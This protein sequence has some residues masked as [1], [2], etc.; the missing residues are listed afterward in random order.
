VRLRH[1]YIIRCDEVV[2]GNDGAPVELHCSV[3]LESR[4]GGANAD[5]KVKGVIHWVSAVHGVH[6]EV[7]LYD[8]LFTTPNPGGLK[9]GRTLLDVLN[10][11]SLQVKQSIVEPH[12]VEQGPGLRVQFERT[13]YFYRDPETEE[14]AVPVFNRI[15][16]LRDTWA[17]LE[18]ANAG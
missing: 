16:T 8:R 2:H 14:G 12:L 15:I 3:D 4:A 13:G 10:P 7:R 5:R 6:C 11:D 1:G 18:K 17:K 9:D